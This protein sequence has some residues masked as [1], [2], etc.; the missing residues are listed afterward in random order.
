MINVYTEGYLQKFQ[1]IGYAKLKLSDFPLYDQGNPSKPMFI[2]LELMPDNARS[3]NPPSVLISIERHRSDD[4]VRHSRK[5]IKPMVYIMRSYCFMARN[6]SYDGMRQDGEARNYGL[7]VSCAGMS[8]TTPFLKGPRPLWMQHQDMRVVLCSDSTKEAPTIEP[9]TVSLVEEGSVFNGDLGKAICVYTHLRRKDNLGKWEPY[10]LSPQWIRVHGGT[11][12][13]K[14][15]GEILI[16]FELMLWKHRDDLHL[17]PRNMWPQPEDA[18]DKRDHLCRLRKATLHFSLIG[19]RDILP[20]PRVDSLGYASGSVNVAQPTV[21]VEVN[22]FFDRNNATETETV[23]PTSKLIFEYR[24]TVPGGDRRVKAERLKTWS[25]KTGYLGETVASNFEF[26]Q[27]GKMNV[28]IPDRV[29]FQPFVTIR[30]L[31]A[32]SGMGHMIG[33]EASVIGESLQDLSKLLPCCW[34]EGVS[35]DEAYQAQKPKIRAR[36]REA[37]EEASVRDKFEQVT[38]EELKKQVK[39]TREAESLSQS[40]WQKK[41]DEMLTHLMGDEQ[42]EFIDST[43]LPEPLR[44]S[45]FKRPLNLSKKVNIQQEMSFSPREGEEAKQVGVG[46]TR[47]ALHC[48]LENSKEPPFEHDF[49]YKNVPLF[50]N[51]DIVKQNDETVDWNYQP[52]LVFGFVKCAFKLTDGWELAEEKALPRADTGASSALSF[53]QESVL[54]DDDDNED[55]AVDTDEQKLKRSFEFSQALDRFAFDEKALINQYK[56]ERIPS[57]IIVRL[58]LVKAV[59]IYGKG[60]G[61]YADPYIGF[62]LGR[63]NP[64]SMRNMAQFQTNTPEFYRI[65]ERDMELPDDGRLEVRIMDLQDMALSDSLIGSTVIDLEDRWHSQAW[66]DRNEL[67]LIPV[68][69]RSLFTQEVIGKNRGSLEMWVEM[70]ESTRASDTLPSDLR[71]PPECE[72]EIRMVIWSTKGVRIVSGDTVSVKLSVALDCKEYNGEHAG[73][74]ETDVHFGSKDGDA[75]FNWRIVYPK[76]KTPVTSCTAMVSVYHYELTGDTFIGSL[77]LDLKKY[78]ERVAKDSD[79]MEIGP[80][81]LKFQGTDSGEH[82]VGSVNMTLYVMTSIEAQSKRVGIGREE[83]N[84]HPS[85][86]TPIEGRDWGTYLESFGFSMPDFGMWKKLIPPVAGAV[87]FLVSL[88]VMKQAGLL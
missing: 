40:T 7:R 35:L 6:I 76:I 29:I 23:Y 66:R 34:L 28:L 42:I 49:W 83:P 15:V 60:T 48:K 73:L 27:V 50:R 71:K 19:L 46:S 45:P 47:R 72:L 31:E 77:N 11:Y 22:C 64:V 3:R 80:A 4:V 86:I 9:I 67:G 12:G 88:V 21:E 75:L 33:Y 17:Q 55:A 78:C 85:L 37:M 70:V 57:R 87:A 84:D 14:P 39:E 44:R 25:S 63:K 5:V 54:E 13:N 51:H 74:Q 20:L 82:V 56:G 26:L 16:A 69:R 32:P 36:L 52:N 41:K 81:D 38:E 10:S 8:K 43:A 53:R 1:R 62:Q 18:F 79:A 61:G 24:D 65:E 58:Y 68:E 2:A 59:V 30:V